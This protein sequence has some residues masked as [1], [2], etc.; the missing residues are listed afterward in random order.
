[1]SPAFRVTARGRCRPRVEPVDRPT[2]PR[3]SRRWRVRYR[4]KARRLITIFA[5][6]LAAWIGLVWLS[7][8]PWW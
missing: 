8:K 7:L 3:L 5:V 6:F 4:R 1:M 2:G